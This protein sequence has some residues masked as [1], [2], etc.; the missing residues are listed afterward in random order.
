[1]TH[2][3]HIGWA[4]LVPLVAALLTTLNSARPNLRE[5]CTLV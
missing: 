1:M 4:L 2:E 5:G 3:Q